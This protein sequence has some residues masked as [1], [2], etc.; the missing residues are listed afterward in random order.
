MT[1]LAGDGD[2][3]VDIVGLA[4][5]V[6]GLEGDELWIS[7]AQRYEVNHSWGNGMLLSVSNPAP[8]LTH[9]WLLAIHEDAGTINLPCEGTRQEDG[10][11]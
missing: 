10:D 11:I 3:R 5:G 9:R 6:K 2:R 1:P 7:R 4:E 8:Y